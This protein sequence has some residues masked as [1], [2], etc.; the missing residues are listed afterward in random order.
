VQAPC[1]AKHD[2]QVSESHFR[3]VS[4]MGEPDI[5][6]GGGVKSVSTVHTDGDL[7]WTREIVDGHV[8]RAATCQ[9]CVR[10][11]T[12]APIGFAALHS[13][14]GFVH[15]LEAA[16]AASFL[17]K[18]SQQSAAVFSAGQPASSENLVQTSGWQGEEQMHRPLSQTV[19]R[20]VGETTEG[21]PCVDA[22]DSALLELFVDALEEDRMATCRSFSSSFC[23]SFIQEP[24]LVEGRALTAAPFPASL[25][26]GEQVSDASSRWFCVCCAKR[27]S[28]RTRHVPL[29]RF[30]ADCTL[31]ESSRCHQFLQTRC[32]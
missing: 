8:D 24:P 28:D 1:F 25:P 22:S 31:M 29:S 17:D 3:T 13:P 26:S 16:R 32:A 20:K 27:L 14:H 2:L 11:A 5:E 9:A 30:K 7:S 15:T 6:A 4:C 19:V 21:S 10:D 18:D 23:S 12:T